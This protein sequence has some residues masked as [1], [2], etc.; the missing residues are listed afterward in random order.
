MK[1][2]SLIPDDCANELFEAIIKMYKNSK[3]KI[4]L[5]RILN[6]YYPIK[7][8]LRQILVFNLL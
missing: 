6:Y 7:A 1:T 4:C 8:K 3:L 2:I 5:K